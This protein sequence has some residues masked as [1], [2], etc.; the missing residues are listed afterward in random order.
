MHLSLLQTDIVWADKYANFEKIT[1]QLASLAGK[2]DL[3]VLPEM[4]S[5]GFFTHRMDLAETMNGET[6]QTLK[7][8]AMQFDLAISGSF[9]ATE[10]DKIY[11]RAFFVFPDGSI[12]TA[13]KR[14]LFSMGKEDAIFSAGNDKL[15]VNYK[16][17]NIMVLVCYDI[18]FPVWSRNVDN[19]Y[20]LLIYVAN[21]PHARVHVWDTL[22][23]ARA[24]ENQ[25]Y[26]CGVNRV[27]K[28]GMDLIYSGHSALLDVR[29][30][31]LISFEENEESAKTTE[32]SAQKLSEFR[33]KF[34]VWKDADQFTLLTQSLRE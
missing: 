22:L 28:D 33:E 32:I 25:A 6:V 16:E 1:R 17:L 13:D 7:A 14:H 27:G 26:V 24:I 15:L 23:Q 5:T 19:A 2:T 9:I 29:G 18:R 10:N 20:D 12:H 30:N 11:N 21:F 4:F 34:A 3:A 8:W 31:T